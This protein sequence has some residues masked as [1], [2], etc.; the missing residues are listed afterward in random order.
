M[1]ARRGPRRTV[2][3]GAIGFQMPLR[4]PRALRPWTHARR[5]SVACH[6]EGRVA[7]HARAVER[8]VE[9]GFAGPWK[10]PTVRDK[11][12]PPHLYS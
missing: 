9:M 8:S 10:P 6:S 5:T 12:G 11:R 2:Q 3:T 1:V 7:P 4:P